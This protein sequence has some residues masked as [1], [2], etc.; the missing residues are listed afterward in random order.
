MRCKAAEDAQVLIETDGGNPVMAVKQ[1]GK[2]RLV[3]LSVRTD[4]L[5]PSFDL[6]PDQRLGDGFEHRYWEVWYDLLA[7]ATFWASGSAFSR[8]GEPSKLAVTGDD[9]DE[10]LSVRQWK[11]EAGKVTDWQ[12]DFV[13]PKRT[14]VLLFVPEMIDRG[15]NIEL[16]F[17]PPQNVEQDGE[18]GGDGDGARR[19]QRAGPRA[20]HARSR[21][22]ECGQARGRASLREYSHKTHVADICAPAADRT[23][24][25]DHR[26]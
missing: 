19:R 13:K 8:D 15:A 5:S 18:V 2:G 26:G 16:G 22:S 9:V 3:T 6:T 23:A 12:L 24:G 11:D 10:N 4:G 1:L 25:Q 20:H 7:R 21:R 17:A 14:V